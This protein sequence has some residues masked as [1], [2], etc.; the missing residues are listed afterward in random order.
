MS[1]SP[2]LDLSV[3]AH[4]S[5]QIYG[6]LMFSAEYPFWFLVAQQQHQANS[7]SGWDSWP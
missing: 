7:P 2:S 3:C 4:V 1:Q 5:Q 6:A